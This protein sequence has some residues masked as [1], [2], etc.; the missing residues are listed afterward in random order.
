MGWINKAVVLL[1][2]LTVLF[3]LSASVVHAHAGVMGTYPEKGQLLDDSPKEIS[4]RLS[5][6]VELDLADIQLFDWNGRMVQVTQPK[7]QPDRSKEVIRKLPDLKP[8]TYTVVWNVV[9]QDG[10]PVSGSFDFS[11]ERETGHVVDVPLTDSHW[12]EGLLGLFRYVVVGLTLLGTGLFW[13]AWVGERRGLP[14]FVQVLGRS[15]LYGGVVL[16]AGI[17]A[18]FASYSATLPGINLFSFWWE[19]KWGL[20]FQFPFVIMLFTQLVTLILLVIPGMGRLWYGIMWLLFSASLSLGGH[21]WGIQD[22][23]MA[24][25]I[26]ILHLWA[27][28]LWLGGLT[29]LVLLMWKSRQSTSPTLAGIR[30]FFSIFAAVASVSVIASGIV[31]VMLQSDWMA[32]WTEKGAWS[33][34]LLIKV[35]LTAL[36]LGLALIQTIRWRKKGGL[37]ASLL[38][39]EWGLGL[40]VILVAVWLSQTPYPLPSNPYH[41]TLQSNG[42][43]AAFRISQLKL[44]SQ[45]ID[46]SL[47]PGRKEPEEVTIRM[48][49][50]GHGMELD[51]VTM[52]RIG[53]GKYQA[54][55]SFTMMGDWKVSVQAEYSDGEDHTW[56]DTIFIPGG[57]YP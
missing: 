5:E 30:S 52:K 49:M 51:P 33:G 14:G 9:S 28:A 44:G 15:R 32:V 27:G 18:Q 53:K 34:Y 10:H 6:S 8:G 47:E 31:M 2:C 41:T 43:K 25:S 42:V 38:R 45:T 48:E 12:S 29:Y 22:P 56:I 36:M 21:V 13:M 50:E 26:R 40:A 35:L 16:F 55:I 11:V 23:M 54:P 19:G 3:G 1:L 7:H 37:L 46:L 20:L 24:I 4:L 57:G 17:V 39:W